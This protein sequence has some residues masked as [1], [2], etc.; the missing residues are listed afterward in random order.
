MH[1]HYSGIEI[2]FI[3]VGTLNKFKTNTQTDGLLVKEYDGVVYPRQGFLAIM[4]IS[5]SKIKQ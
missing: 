3:E 2:S 5:E 4:K 1:F